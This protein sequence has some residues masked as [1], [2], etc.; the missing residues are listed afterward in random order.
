MQKKS[1][2]PSDRVRPRKS[3]N[4]DLRLLSRIKAGLF[5]L[6]C[7]LY[8]NTLTHDY[9]QDDAIV[10]YENMFTTQGVS[11]IPG[12]LSK[13]TFFG[14]FKV[15]GKS[16]LVQGGRYRP[17]T[18]VMFAIEYQLVGNA[19]WL[20][21]FINMLLYG[22]TGVVVFLFL[23]WMGNR[24]KLSKY[25]LEFAIAGALLYVTHPLHTEAVANIKGR[26]EMMAFLL[27]ILA[28]WIAVRQFPAQKIQ[29]TV[30]SVACF[31][32]ALLAKENAITFLL[33]IPLTWVFFAHT[34]W[35]QAIKRT[36]PYF[37]AALAFLLIRGQV[38][39]WSFGDK[40]MEMMNNPFIKIVHNQYMP[41]SGAETTATILFTLGKYIQLL[42]VPHPLTHDYYP[43][44]IGIMQFGDWQVML[45]LLLYLGLGALAMVGFVRRQVWAY[46]ILFFLITI[47]IVSN[48]VFPV[49]TNMS[50]RFTYMP[51]LGWSIALGALFVS[52]LKF[53]A[54]LAWGV[55]GGVILLFSIRTVT[56]NTVWKDNLTLFTT[57]IHTSRNSAKLLSAT[58]GEIITQYGMK[59]AS[60][61]R[62]ALLR[63]ALA[64]LDRAQEIHPNYKLTYL[65]EGNGNFFLKQ[66]D[67]AIAAYQ[68]VQKLDPS[69][70]D[71]RRNLGVAYRD[72]GRYF[73][74]HENNLTKSIT[75]LQE[76]LRIL[77]EDYETVHGLGV[78]YGISGNAAQALAYFQKGVEL[79]PDNPT[80]H[81]N[82]GLAYQR[83]GDGVNA[84]IHHDR[85]VALDPQIIERRRGG[86]NE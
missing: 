82:L 25:A 18:P 85:A 16:R 42:F 60:P 75:Y 73:G 35:M 17:L 52:L 12:L 34:T 54:R 2:K 79:A 15:E 9:T 14:F 84:Q 3:A 11:G 10:I 5:I 37:A 66:W 40:P 78:A 6:G 62:D 69:D 63:D 29:A 41:F 59:P 28:L 61:E 31:F 77:P 51:S 76:A 55:L 30:L 7:L 64:Y 21:H 26:D 22:L 4:S 43:R 58:A 47:S 81:F 68:Q 45:S 19:P 50:E 24:S 27:G 56:R 38:I 53:N 39:G 20:G 8:A 44:H 72:A 33:V 65:L 32:L 1:K 23:L 70:T 49:G 67:A 71:A 86:G 57:D 74:E 36:V 13:D 80:A 46:G 83:I 48:V